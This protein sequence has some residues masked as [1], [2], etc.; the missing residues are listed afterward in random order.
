MGGG[1]SG[2]GPGTGMP[3][4]QRISGQSREDALSQAVAQAQLAGVDPQSWR[5]VDTWD[6]GERHIAPFGPE[7]VLRPGEAW[8]RAMD[9]NANAW[10]MRRMSVG[11]T[12]ELD[13]GR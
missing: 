9:W 6:G 2:P 3:R 10:T 5:H 8:V 1:V 13:L 4:Y 12:A 7:I 11:I